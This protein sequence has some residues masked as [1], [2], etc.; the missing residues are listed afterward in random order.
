MRSAPFSLPA[1][2]LFR[3]DEVLTLAIGIFLLVTL[4]DLVGSIVR[5][6]ILD[7]PTITC[8]PQDQPG[9]RDRTI[10][11]FGRAEG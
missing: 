10:G 6:R 2:S 9:L 11:A 1:S 4:V 8:A 5:A 3:Y 7:A